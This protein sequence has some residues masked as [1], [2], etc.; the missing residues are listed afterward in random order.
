MI[1]TGPEGSE[2]VC[3]RVATTVEMGSEDE[4]DSGNGQESGING[5]STP[6]NSSSGGE[7]GSDASGAILVVPHGLG[8]AASAVAGVLAAVWL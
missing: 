7:G 4:S 2:A 5:E 8:L 1:L 6:E 3:N